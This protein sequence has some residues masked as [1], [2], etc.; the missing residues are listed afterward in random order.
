MRVAVTLCLTVLL[1][2]A[3]A[4]AA[5]P[6]VLVVDPW[7]ERAPSPAPVAAFAPLPE[8]VDPWAGAPPL[9]LLETEEIVDPWAAYHPT[10]PTAAFPLIE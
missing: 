6:L 3:P 9:A 2:A 10:I 8:I 5:E 4:G 1:G 7:L